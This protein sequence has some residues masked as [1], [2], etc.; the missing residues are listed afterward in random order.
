MRTI[1]KR[2]KLIIFKSDGMRLTVIE[3]QHTADQVPRPKW[4]GCFM[5]NGPMVNVTGQVPRI[6]LGGRACRA[7][8][9]ALT[10][11]WVTEASSHSGCVFI[12]EKNRQRKRNNYF[13]ISPKSSEVLDLLKRA[14]GDEYKSYCMQR[15]RRARNRL[16]TTPTLRTPSVRGLV[17]L[18]CSNSYPPFVVDHTL[19]C[20]NSYPPF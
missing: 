10:S 4:K 14:G 19:L 3:G 18:L 1:V 16:D 11:R 2:K 20:S 17:A 6:E 12:I 8:D 13:I 15:R 5:T 7:L 9:R